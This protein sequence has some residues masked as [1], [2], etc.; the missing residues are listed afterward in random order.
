[1]TM[2]IVI[3]GICFAVAF[4]GALVLGMWDDIKPNTRRRRRM[5]DAAL[6]QTVRV[7]SWYAYHIGMIALAL[8][9]AYC[10]IDAVT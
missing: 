3:V 9:G 8:Y 2:E 7:A 5:R 4:G 6:G 10:M 1:M